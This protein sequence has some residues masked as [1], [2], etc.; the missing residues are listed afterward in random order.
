MKLEV[1][2]KPCPW[3]RKTPEIYMPIGDGTWCWDIR[4]ANES[5]SM[6]P[7]TPYVSIRN[8][9]KY[10]FDNFYEKLRYMANTW[11]GGNPFPP[12]DMK[13]IDLA[14]LPELNK[15]AIN[16]FFFSPDYARINAI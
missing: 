4:C 16:F 7:K 15:S 8:T 1:V 5:C 13:V 14:P 2:L 11:N 6:K 12:Y 9:T 3:C 10:M